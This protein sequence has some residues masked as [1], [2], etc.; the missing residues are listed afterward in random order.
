[1]LQRGE[2]FCSRA[3][4]FAPRQTFLLQSKYICPKIFALQVLVGYNRQPQGMEHIDVRVLQ[5][6]QEAKGKHHKDQRA[7]KVVLPAKVRLMTQPASH[8]EGEPT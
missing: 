3:N 6:T 1:M 8:M 7:P 5:P 2:L 4:L